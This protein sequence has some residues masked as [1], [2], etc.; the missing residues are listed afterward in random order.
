MAKAVQRIKRGLACPLTW[1]PCTEC[2]GLV[3]GP[4]GRTVHPTCERL[5]VVRW[6]RERRRQRPGQS[7]PYVA[8]Y[9]KLQPEAARQ[10]R[11]REKAK[12]RDQWPDLPRPVREASLSK[13][14]QADL[15]DYAVTLPHATASGD[16]WTE[17][18]DQAIIDGLKR[19][20]REIALELGRTLWSVRNRRV[21][22]RRLGLL[23]DAWAERRMERSE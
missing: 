19:P 13:V 21:R 4:R 1:L 3:A 7:T 11:E 14:H 15:R 5:R 9:R 18:E 6:A 16:P 23:P 10:L 17:E 22:L 12:L 20:A 8:R 2:G